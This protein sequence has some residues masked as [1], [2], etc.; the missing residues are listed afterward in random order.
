[1]VCDATAAV[2]CKHLSTCGGA[3][4]QAPT[5]RQH[6]VEHGAGTHC[7]PTLR[8]P[9]L[10]MRKGL[11]MPT[12]S[13]SGMPHDSFSHVRTLTIWSARGKQGARA[14]HE[15]PGDSA[16]CCTSKLAR[17]WQNKNQ[18]SSVH[19]A[20]ELNCRHAGQLLSAALLTLLLGI[21]RGVQAHVV[22]RVQRNLVALAPQLL[23]QVAVGLGVV[24]DGEPGVWNVGHQFSE[25]ASLVG[26]K[27]ATCGTLCTC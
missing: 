5:H 27:P 3:P 26:G 23:H 1:M 6:K 20:P 9:G 24:L 17:P 14:R 10:V 21:D 18:Y 12:M 11:R 25:T 13:L 16:R 15:T 4:P 2:Q 8:M 19:I 22:A 7:Q